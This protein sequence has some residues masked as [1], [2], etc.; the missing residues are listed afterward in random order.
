MRATRPRNE[1][2]RQTDARR[3]ARSRH[4]AGIASEPA[5]PPLPVPVE[6]KADG[7]PLAGL[8]IVVTGTLATLSRDEAKA[9]VET[10]GGRVG[11]DVSARTNL[12]VAG[13]AAG[14]KL[15]KAKA[16]GIEVIDEAEF[17]RRAGRAPNGS[18][19]GTPS[20]HPRSPW[21]ARTPDSFAIVGLTDLGHFGRSAANAAAQ[22]D[23]SVPTSRPS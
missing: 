5:P 20:V 17:L 14:S 12:L 11:S 23:A 15:K 22:A 8:T 21:G 3:R 6:K 2:A 4:R 18:S 13:E 7:G 9:L 10:L 19:R 1:G 16:L